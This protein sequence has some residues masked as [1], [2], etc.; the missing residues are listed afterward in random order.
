MSEQ[1]IK[2]EV[3]VK[4]LGQMAITNM[5]NQV[6]SFASL[7]NQKLSDKETQYA[8]GIITNINKKVVSDSTLSWNILDIQGCQL[9]AQIK[10]YARLNLQLENQE[11]FLD[12]RNNGK[13]G[14]KDI[15]IKMQYQGLEKLLMRYCDKKVIRFKKDVICKG[16]DFEQIEDFDSGITKISKHVYFKTDDVDYRNKLENIIGA[17]AIA[18]VE[19]YG[20]LVPYTCIIDKNRIERAR[21][22]AMTKTIW[23]VDTRKMTLK[24]ACWELWNVMK[25]FMVMPQDLVEDFTRATEN[26]VDFNNKDFIN[27]SASDV[28]DVVNENITNAQELQNDFEEFDNEN[29]NVESDLYD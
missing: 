1:T 2:N 28:K 14:L 17:Y 4:D 7:E 5:L 20:K 26:E 10:R 12:I 3:K 29:K 21:K 13:T 15:N 16:D 11:I 19:E 24:T 9:P 6:N 8:V 18:Y 25:P 22:S 27:V 23:D